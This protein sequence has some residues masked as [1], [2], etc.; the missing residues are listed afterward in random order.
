[1]PYCPEIISA[2]ISDT[3]ATPMPTVSPV[4]TWGSEAG[5]YTSRKIERSRAPRHCGRPHQ[6]RIDQRHAVQCIHQD[7][8]EGA[9]ESDEDDALLVGRPQ[10][11]CHRHPG[12]RGN[13]AQDFGDR[14]DHLVDRL[15]RPITRPSG[16]PTS[17]ASEKPMKMR[18]QLNATC[19][20]NFGSW[21]AL[22]KLS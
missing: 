21:I 13:R 2:A 12:D 7:R 11:D 4:K 14:K 8:K 9:E 22:A 18:R 16:T 1:M 3:Q 17:A 6:H 5:K 15:K 20:K 10:H 19:R